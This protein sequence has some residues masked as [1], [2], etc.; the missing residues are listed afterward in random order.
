MARRGRGMVGALR[1]GL[2]EVGPA[3]DRMPSKQRVG[4]LVVVM[5][6]SNE[7]AG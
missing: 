2:R 7:W 1:R 5:G 3:G 6:S 4:W